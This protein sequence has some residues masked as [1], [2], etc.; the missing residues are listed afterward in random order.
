MNLVLLFEDDFIAGT[1]R[2]CLKGRRLRHVLTVHRA[3]AGDSLCVGLA[4]GAIGT[5]VITRLDSTVLEMEILLDRTPPPPLPATLLLALPRPK[6]V[7]R[8]L[9]IA[10]TLGVKRIILLNAFR[11]EK[12]FWQSPALEQESIAGQLIIGLEQ[13]RDTLLPEIL[14]RPRFKPFVED[15]LPALIRGTLPLVAHPGS[16]R[17]CPRSVNRPVTVAVGPEGGFIPY[18]MEMLAACGFTAVNLGERILRVETAVPFLL[19]KLF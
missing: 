5:G 9:L 19:A 11:V 1:S 10:A 14:L 6:V 7:K 16:P 17:P 12:S 18:E 3:V 2:V 13:S 4:G 15:E 8:V